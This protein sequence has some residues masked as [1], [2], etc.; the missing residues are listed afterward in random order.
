MHGHKL[1]ISLLTT[2]PNIINKNI[3]EIGSTREI[4]A[5]QNSSE[6]LYNLSK[7]INFNF[8]TVDMDPNNIN[9]LLKRLP[10]INA[11]CCRGED[12][13]KNYSDHIDYLYLDAFDFD[14]SQHSDKRKLSYKKYLGCDIT[15]DLCHKTHLEFCKN[16]IDKM[17]VGSTI[18][19]DDVIS[20]TVGKGVKAIP[21]LLENNFV[22]IKQIPNC[23]ALI[24]KENQ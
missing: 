8:T 17:P 18:V 20:N 14:H 9:S 19:I 11:I 12:F 2:D 3:I 23:I 6:E 7:K 16:S 24:K 21:F 4:S 5:G 13:L 1:L 15:N 10:F 22:I